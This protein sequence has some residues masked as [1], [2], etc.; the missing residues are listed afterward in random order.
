MLWVST[1]VIR[2]YLAGENTGLA[3]ILVAASGENQIVVA[4]GANAAFHAQH[5]RLPAADA[6]IAQLEVPL[7][8][9]LAAARANGK[10][11][12]LNAAPAKPVPDEILALTDLLVVNEIEA[13]AIGPA[14]G[15][16]QGLVATTLGGAGAV[17]TRG[18]KEL[19]R[20]DAPKVEVV[21]TTG[22]GD[23]FTAALTV[24]LVEGMSPGEALQRACTAGAISVTRPGAQGS[25][26]LSELA[27]FR[28]D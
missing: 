20:A 25:P 1:D 15:N 2:R 13:R 24:G 9:I 14:L 16:F 27:A 19:A 3:L 23:S 21:D 12:T 10:F 26:T 8:T 6:V 17:L 28:A 22:A 11:F 5:L 4:P 18:A 7:D